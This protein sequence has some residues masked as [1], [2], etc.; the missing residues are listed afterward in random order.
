MNIEEYLRRLRSE[1]QQIFEKTICYQTELG[2]AHHFSA[3]VNEFSEHVFDNVEKNILTTVSTQLESATFNVTMG[4]YRQAF[5]SLRLAFEMGIGVVYFSVHRLELNEWLC[6]QADLKWANLLDESNGILSKRFT[7]A[8]YKELSDEVSHY[9]HLA[10]SVYR[11]LSEFVH[12]NNETWELSGLTLKYNEQLLMK[13]FKVYNDVSKVV[14]FVLCCRYLRS[15]S[16]EVLDSL[17]FIPEEFHHIS[18]IREQFGG[19]KEL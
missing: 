17:E 8:F 9:R 12:G 1:S 19:P 4:L 18:I 15:F 2:K 3:C 5:S 13:Y 16:T 10:K 6:G 11:E 7:N 14:L